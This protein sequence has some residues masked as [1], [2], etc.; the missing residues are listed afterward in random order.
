MRFLSVDLTFTNGAGSTSSSMTETLISNAIDVRTV[1]GFSIQFKYTGSPVG[2]MTIEAT[3]DEIVP[4][5]S[6][7]WVTVAGSSVAVS[8]SGDWIYNV[9][10]SNLGSVRL[11]YTFSSGTG[12]LTAK[13][14]TKG[15]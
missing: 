1:Y 15:V 11:K 14:V 7:N 3:D 5:V 8:G 4:A 6:Q 2:T 12:T 13:I 10:D 9:A